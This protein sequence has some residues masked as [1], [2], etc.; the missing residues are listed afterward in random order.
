[1]SDSNREWGENTDEAIRRRNVLSMARKH[2]LISPLDDGFQYFWFKDLRAM[3]ATDLRIVA[4]ELDRLNAPLE[5]QIAEDFNP[6]T[7]S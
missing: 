1:M 5:K 4:D 6:K 7:E 2:R 3:T